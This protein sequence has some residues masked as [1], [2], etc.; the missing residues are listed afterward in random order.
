MLQPYQA[1]GGLGT[2]CLW[3]GAAFVRASAHNCFPPAQGSCLPRR[4]S[5]PLQQA[6]ELISLKGK[7]SYIQTEFLFSLKFANVFLGSAAGSLQIPAGVIPRSGHLALC[8][9]PPA[10]RY[11][12]TKQRLVLQLG[13]LTA[14][15]NGCNFCCVAGCEPQQL[16]GWGMSASAALAVGAAAYREQ[17]EATASAEAGVTWQQQRFHPTRKRYPRCLTHVSHG[18]GRM[19]LCELQCVQGMQCRGLLG[20]FIEMDSLGFSGGFIAWI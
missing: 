18:S 6:L 12:Q 14:H 11:G 19:G 1:F 13:Q 3:I 7:D 9:S 10:L 16:R 4:H 15:W 5:D 8:A 20:A 17:G 2:L